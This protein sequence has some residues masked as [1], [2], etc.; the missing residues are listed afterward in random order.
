MRTRNGAPW[1][2]LEPTFFWGFSYMVTSRANFFRPPGK[3]RS[4]IR[5]GGGGGSTFQSLYDSYDGNWRKLFCFCFVA[6]KVIDYGWCKVWS[7]ENDEGN[8]WADGWNSISYKVFL[9][10]MWW[11]VPLGTASYE[12]TESLEIEG[13]IDWKEGL[14]FV[15]NLTQDLNWTFWMEC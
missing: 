7:S 11:A 1:T 3:Y 15:W 4:K 6:V 5:K 8:R 12:R 14:K 10:A 2:T 9:S 13:W